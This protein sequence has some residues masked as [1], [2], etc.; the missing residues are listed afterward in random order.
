MGVY[1]WVFLFR[2][3]TR[4]LCKPTH[5]HMPHPRS[6]LK[7]QRLKLS[8]LRLQRSCGFYR[9]YIGIKGNAPDKIPGYPETPSNPL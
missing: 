5:G 2:E 6:K 3:T 7:K 8:K 9:S 1:V 4:L